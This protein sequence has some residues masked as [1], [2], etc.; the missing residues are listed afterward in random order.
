[1]YALNISH[2]VASNQI[3][4]VMAKIGQ[5]LIINFAPRP[6]VY[7]YHPVAMMISPCHILGEVST[8]PLI[9]QSPTPYE[10]RR[11]ITYDVKNKVGTENNMQFKS[12]DYVFMFLSTVSF[13]EDN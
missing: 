3:L 4:L 11:E 12:N 5:N 10:D 9:L 13:S 6:K 1:M 2:F 7:F 8:N